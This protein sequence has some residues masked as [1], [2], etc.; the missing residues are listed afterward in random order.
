M[1]Y[2][3]LESIRRSRYISKSV[4]ISVRQR[5]KDQC[6]FRSAE[7]GKRCESKIDL[8]FEHV[9]TFSMGGEHTAQNIKHYC[10]T[11]NRLSAILVF[12]KEKMDQF[13]RNRN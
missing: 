7:T 9:R 12:G 10:A 13:L 11:H 1:Q 3:K 8:Q 6:E 5:S 2:D 4:Q